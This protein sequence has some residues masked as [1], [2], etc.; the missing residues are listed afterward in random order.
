MKFERTYIPGKSESVENGQF[1]F[2][3][4]DKNVDV[5]RRVKI[6]LRNYPVLFARCFYGLRYVNNPRM[7]RDRGRFDVTVMPANTV[8]GVFLYENYVWFRDLILQT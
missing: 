7:W 3:F 6:Q 1:F 5:E 2:Y 4:S 8:L